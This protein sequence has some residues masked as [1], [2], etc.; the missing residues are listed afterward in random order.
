MRT[1]IARSRGAHRCPIPTR[2]PDAR[3]DQRAPAAGANCG[4]AL[5]AANAL[6]EQASPAAPSR[7]TRM[8]VVHLA[9]RDAKSAR[10]EFEKALSLDADFVAATYN[11]AMLDIG[12]GNLASAR[13]RYEQVLA[14]DPKS[15]PGTAGAGRAADAQ[16]GAARRTSTRRSSARSRPTRASIAPRLALIRYLRVEPK[17]WKAA[18]APR[19]EAAHAAIPDSPQILDA[20]AAAQQ[21]PA[22]T[23]R[24]SRRSA[25][26]RSCSRTT[27]RR[28]CVLAGIQAR[29]RTSRARLPPCA[30]RLVISPD[31]FWR[32]GLRLPACT[33]RPIRSMR[34][35]RRRASSRRIVRA[36]AVGFALEGELLGATEEVAG[37]G[38][39]LSGLRS[40]KQQ[41][42]V[43]GDP[44]AR[45][46]ARA[47]QSRTR[48]RRSSQ[49]WVKDHPNDVTVRT[50][51]GQQSLA[52]SDY[53]AAVPHFRAAL[54]NA[55]GERRHCSTTSHGR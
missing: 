40:R 39:S 21:P 16:Q 41:M 17:D 30:A 53:K 20:L 4:K 34:V 35:S 33:R 10:A 9:K 43:R 44:A 6:V 7:T 15:D 8:G 32:S 37:G 52:K 2:E 5:A 23:I 25:G 14:K 47:W 38:G 45:G 12:E 48:R 49:K 13:K 51:L 31:K 29:P 24:R 50:Y 1:G 28:W 54:A 26:S 36:V 18:L 42:P 11:L 19:R 55:A 46:P 27:R 22:K 3:V